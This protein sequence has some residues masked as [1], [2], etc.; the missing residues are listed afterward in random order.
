MMTSATPE[1]TPLDRD[2]S[3]NDKS[4][5]RVMQQLVKKLTLPES[6]LRKT[7]PGEL[8]EALRSSPLY[9]TSVRASLAKTLELIDQA[10]V[11]AEETENSDVE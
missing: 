6:F 7:E 8:V 4:S 9:A 5:R 1:T 2:A 3:T 11:Q 10:L